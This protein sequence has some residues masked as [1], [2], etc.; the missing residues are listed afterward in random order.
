MRAI[1]VKYNP[2]TDETLVRVDKEFNQLPLVQRLDCLRDA[3]NDIG[4]EYDRLR[5]EFRA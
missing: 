2:S 4:M 5:D 1:L 3:I